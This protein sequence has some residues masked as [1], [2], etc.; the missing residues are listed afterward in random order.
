[1]TSGERAGEE[2]AASVFSF[3]EATTDKTPREKLAVMAASQADE[4]LPPSD[5]LITAVFW[6]FLDTMSFTAQLKPAMTPDAVP[7]AP[8][9]TLTAI[10]FVFLAT[11]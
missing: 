11:P 8:S 2:F 7:D 1:M 5:M 3:P 10:R 4:A 9:K 6:R